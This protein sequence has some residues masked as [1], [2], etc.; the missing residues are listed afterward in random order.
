MDVPAC[1]LHVSTAHEVPRAIVASAHAVLS[2]RCEANR[3]FSVL[4]TDDE[5]FMVRGFVVD[6]R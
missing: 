6:R 2:R 4:L 5:R 1:S 3:T